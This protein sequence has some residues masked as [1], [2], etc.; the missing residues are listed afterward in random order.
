MHTESSRVL[1]CTYAMTLTLSSG[2]CAFGRHLAA[3]K[4]S[5][6][7]K[8]IP[9][10]GEHHPSRLPASWDQS[11]REQK[12]PSITEWVENSAREIPR[13][14][15]CETV[16]SC[17]PSKK[18]PSAPHPKVTQRACAHP[19]HSL[20]AGEGSAAAAVRS[21]GPPVGAV[22]SGARRASC[23]AIQEGCKANEQQGCKQQGGI[24]G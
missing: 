7:P 19:P 1:L 10:V 23:A 3:V 14:G 22:C 11:A 17:I 24:A 6:P 15:E 12:Q 20:V 9:W 5:H 18:W 16:K 21:Q 13:A 8:C 4:L 2:C